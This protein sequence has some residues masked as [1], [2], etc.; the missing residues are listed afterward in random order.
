MKTLVLATSNPGKIAELQTMLP[1]VHCISQSTLN[2]PDADETG[3]SFIENAIIKAR[4]ASRISQLPALADDSGLVVKA[5]NGAPGIYSARFAGPNASSHDNIKLL[6]SQLADTPDEKRTAYFYCALALVEH[7]DDPTPLLATGMLV[8]R[9][10]HECCGQQG[11]GY[12]P[13][14]YI[15]EY[16]C[17][18]A[19]LPMEIKNAISHRAMA[20]KQLKQLKST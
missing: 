6:L 19:E 2:I 14:F 5:L 9:I 3:L 4:H 16:Q 13:V 1:D 8:G 7:A 11:F 18:A 12:D 17:T 15:P 10:N 20:L